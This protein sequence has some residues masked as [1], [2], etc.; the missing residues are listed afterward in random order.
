V[1]MPSQAFG[2]ELSADGRDEVATAGLGQA[3]SP[4]RIGPKGT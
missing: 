2:S 3:T 4:V 1:T